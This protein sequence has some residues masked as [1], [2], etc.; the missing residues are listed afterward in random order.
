MFQRATKK[1]AKARIGLIGPS[2]SGK[3]YTAL[4]LATNMGKKIALIDTEHGSASKYADKFSFDVLELANYHPQN[5][6][7]GIKNAETAGYDVLI[8]DSLSHAWS[9]TGGIL[10]IVDTATAKSRS[11]N[12]F[13]TGWREATPIHNDL[14]DTILSAKLHLIATMR[15]KTEY[16]LE[17]DGKGG[18][19][20]RKVGMA[21]VQRDGM[22]YEFDIVGDMDQQHNFI[23]SK[24][25]CEA[26]D[27]AV[28]NKPGV[29]LAAQIMEWL[30]DGEK[31]DPVQ[32]EI[33]R[34]RKELKMT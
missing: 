16:V 18:K 34:L 6:I 26:L 15:S 3:T 5:Y 31:V 10:D 8:V 19:R 30:S 20:P 13:T 23:I 21:P 33:N 1:Q 17:D 11:G 28:I 32:T 9:G 22:E 12:A 24:T 4:M 14:I 7:D 29:E 27:G 25:R 2:G